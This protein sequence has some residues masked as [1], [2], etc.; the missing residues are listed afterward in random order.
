MTNTAKKVESKEQVKTS[1][2]VVKK[3]EKAIAEIPSLEKRIQK[4][5]D[6]SMLIEKWRKLTDTNRNLQ[7]FS[8]GA[9][10]MGATVFLRDASGK[11][12][13]TSNTPVVSA[14]MDEIKSTLDEKIKEVENQIKFYFLV[15]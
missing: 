14:V 2:E 7:T 6:L 13:K 15:V 4:V 8:L 3:E 9:D 10:G 12:F 1:M 11:E 5:E